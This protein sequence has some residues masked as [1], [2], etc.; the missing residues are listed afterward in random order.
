[1]QKNTNLEQVK[2]AISDFLPITFFEFPYG[3]TSEV[4]R[5]CSR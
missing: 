2:K 1:M 5:D 4:K 3:S